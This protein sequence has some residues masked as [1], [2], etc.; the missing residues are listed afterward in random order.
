MIWHSAP[1]DTR[2]AIACNPSDSNQC[3]NSVN[4][5]TS[6]CVE[7]ADTLI[8]N[9]VKDDYSVFDL[10]RALGGMKQ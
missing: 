1:L 6:L 4:V 5:S 8:D 10:Y 7:Y 9:A 2:V 3:P